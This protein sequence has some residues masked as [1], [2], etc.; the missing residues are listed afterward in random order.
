MGMIKLIL[1]MMIVFSGALIGAYYSRKLIRRKDT[2]ASFL[3]LFQRASIMIAYEN[4]DLCKLFSDNFAGYDFLYDKSFDIQWLEFIDRFHYVLKAKDRE[5]LSDF[6][7][8][9]GVSDVESQQRHLA[10][11][12]R[13]LEE[14]LDDAGEEVIGK[15]RLYQVLPLS[16]GIVVSLLLI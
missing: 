10:M 8:N 9:M 5:I 4:S 15:S 13:L 7:R 3:S 6:I 11:Y 2:L 14:Q 12:S 1:C 16:A